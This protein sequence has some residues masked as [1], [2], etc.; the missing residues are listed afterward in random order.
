M[1]HH[2]VE[3]EHVMIEALGGGNV[4]RLDVGDDAP[5]H[6]GKSFLC[7]LPKAAACLG[8]C[9]QAERLSA[10]TS[11]SIFISGLLSWQTIIVAAGRMSPKASPRIGNTAST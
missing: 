9:I 5:D 4:A 3:A 8:R 1:V 6:Y 2:Q 10:V 11:I 7:M